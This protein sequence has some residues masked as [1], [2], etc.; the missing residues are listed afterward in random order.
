MTCV[1]LDVDD[2]LTVLPGLL[3]EAG[4]LLLSLT[5]QRVEDEMRSE[6]TVDKRR[7]MT[8]AS[9]LARSAPTLLVRLPRSNMVCMRMLDIH[10]PCLRLHRCP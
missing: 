2:G 1:S 6:E 5:R 4:D 7:P 9:A 8:I 3:S 10:P